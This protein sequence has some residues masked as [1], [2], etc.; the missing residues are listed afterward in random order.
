FSTPRISS[1]E[2]SQKRRALQQRVQEITDLSPYLGWWRTVESQRPQGVAGDVI[3]SPDQFAAREPPRP[4]RDA[5][6]FSVTSPMAV[7]RQRPCVLDVWAHPADAYDQ[8]LE[9]VRL[10]PRA[11][12][13]VSI[14]SKGPVPV[15]RGTRLVV[16]LSVPGLNWEDTDSVYWA[17]T[18][19]N[20]TFSF[21]VPAQAEQGDHLGYVQICVAGVE[22]ARLSFLIT[23][24]ETEGTVHDVSSRQRRV[25]T[26]F[27]SY[28]TEDRAEVLARIQGMLSVVPDLD[29]FM[30][31]VALRSGER[32]QERLEEEITGRDVLYLF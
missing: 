14:R 18:I 15:G 9:Y 6:R 24:A 11:R 16:R 3:P 29:I 23:V 4:I 8:V 30:D 22:I 17:G 12:S 2:G 31:V 21:T 7:V 1:P 10:D 5:V 20:A 27:A 13:G 28:A 32:W 19:G 26:A 25:S